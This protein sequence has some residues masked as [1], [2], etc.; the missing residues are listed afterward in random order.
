VKEGRVDNQLEDGGGSS[1]RRRL[2]HS[3]Q[4]AIQGRA[5]DR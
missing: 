2:N 4:A 1:E 5:P 3:I